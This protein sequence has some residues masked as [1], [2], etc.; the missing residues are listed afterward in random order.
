MRLKLS[1]PAPEPSPEE[2]PRPAPRTEEPWLR[3]GLVD[4]GNVIAGF[5]H[6]RASEQIAALPGSMMTLDQV[7]EYLFGETG[8]DGINRRFERGDLSPEGFWAEAR[9]EMR[10]R[11]PMEHFH[12]AWSD[13]FWID[14]EVVRFLEDWSRTT[15]LYLC[16]NTNSLHWEH[17][18]RL[19][20]GLKNLFKGFFLSYE[21][22]VRKPDEAYFKRV[23]DTLGLAPAE[24]LFVDDS[25]MNVEAASRLGIRSV[26][27]ESL[28]N[29]RDALEGRV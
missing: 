12:R 15:P 21:M 1:K 13:I 24:C 4:L 17:I 8:H 6:H 20:P 23:V 3:A 14:Q 11:C 7:H 9:E 26:R 16:S 22:R 18:A 28:K 29:L 25:R 19:S 2:A 10:L 5:S 27:F